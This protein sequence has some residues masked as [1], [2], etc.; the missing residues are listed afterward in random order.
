[1]SLAGCQI[2]RIDLNFHLQKC[3]E[4]FDKDSADKIQSNKYEGGKS[5]LPRAN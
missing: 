4:T 3:L 1:M 5:T 2:I